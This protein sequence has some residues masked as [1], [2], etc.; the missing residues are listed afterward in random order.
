MFAY[1]FHAGMVHG[2]PPVAIAV[3]VI[4]LLHGQLHGHRAG[5]G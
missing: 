2:I 5:R 1:M 3:A 4:L